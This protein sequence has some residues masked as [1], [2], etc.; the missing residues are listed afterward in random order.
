VPKAHI[1]DLPSAASYAKVRFSSPGQLT[2][3][4]ALINAQWPSKVG[5]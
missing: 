4:R 5:S 2:R 1:N 3:A